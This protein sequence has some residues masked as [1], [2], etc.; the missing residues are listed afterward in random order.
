MT[1]HKLTALDLF[2]I[3]DTLYQSL[4]IA[5]Y[6]GRGTVEGR[7]HVLEKICD[8]MSLMKVEVLTDTPDATTITADTGI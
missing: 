3:Q 1:N 8:I 7:Q 5:N 2:I 6:S 4:K